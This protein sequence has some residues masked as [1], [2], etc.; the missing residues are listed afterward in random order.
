M[1]IYDLP[2]RI[3]ITIINIPNEVRRTMYVQSGNANKEI[4]IKKYR[5][6][7]SEEYNN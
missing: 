6:L 3:K 2:N 1:E 4:N 5:N 7:R